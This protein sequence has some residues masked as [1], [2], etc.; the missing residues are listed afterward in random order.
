MT[1]DMHAH[2]SPPELIDIYR[3]RTSPPMI[4]TNASGE[5]V[6]KTR[7]GEQPFDGMFD[8]LGTRLAEMDEH[9]VTT[10]V[11]SLWGPH[12]WIERLPVEESVAAV[13]IFNDAVSKLCAQYPGRFIAYAS[14]PQA[15][16]QAAVAELDRAMAMPGMIGAIVPGN[17]FMTLADT[18]AYR[19]LL[20]AANRHRAA[21]FIHWG[22]RPGDQWPRTSADAD[23]FVRRMGTL[24]MQAN[25][26]ACTITLTMTDLLD[27]Y[28]DACF[29]IH[30][31]GGNIAFEVERLDHRSLLDTPEQPLP[32]TRLTKSNLW[33]DCNSFGAK[34]IEL[35]VNLYGVD[36]IVYATDGT[37][38]GCDWTNK[39]LAAANL[40]EEQREMIR[41]GNAQ[42]MLGHLTPLADVAQAAE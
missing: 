2:W 29:H 12:Q 31:L 20:A 17:A 3:A 40:T 11:L 26:S 37:A 1:I 9:G 5:E 24:D 19:P 36:R 39:A 23:N 15:D 33:Y 41:S 8:H 10:G 21:L 22:P 16:M 14:L 13:K 18:D 6:I 42:N 35:A 38:F 25:L 27:E 30:N 34:S 4:H 7:R 28:P 32:S